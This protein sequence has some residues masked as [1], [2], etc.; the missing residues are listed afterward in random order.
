MNRIVVLICL[1]AVL[2][3][4]NA[5][6]VRFEL[7]PETAKFKPGPGAELVTAQCLLCHSADYV[8]TQPRLARATW[9]AGVEKMRVKYGA[10]ISTNQVELLVDYLVRNYGT[11]VTNAEPAAPSVK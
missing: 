11:E 5:A 2:A 8:S 10:P 4:S 6:P 3:S 7:P 9:K 1:V